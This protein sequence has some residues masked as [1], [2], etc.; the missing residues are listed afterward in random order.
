MDQTIAPRINPKTVPRIPT[1][2][3]IFASFSF[4]V[5]AIT[6]KIIAAG[7][8]R[9]GKNRKDIAPKMMARIEK[10]LLLD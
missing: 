1:V 8:K 3:A 5:F 10:V 7:P 6:A 2:I 4:L 9:I